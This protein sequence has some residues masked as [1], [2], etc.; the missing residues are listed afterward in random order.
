[1]PGGWINPLLS[2]CDE[3]NQIV[4]TVRARRQCGVALLIAKSWNIPIQVSTQLLD[5]NHRLFCGMDDATRGLYLW[6]FAWSSV[7]LGRRNFPPFSLKE[8]PS[9]T[10]YIL[11]FGFMIGL[12]LTVFGFFCWRVAIEEV[13]FVPVCTSFF[14]LEEL[15]A[16]FPRFVSCLTFLVLLSNQRLNPPESGELGFL[17]CHIRLV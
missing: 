15:F 5:V 9:S 16:E 6:S 13:C 10:V 1:M 2:D 17:S 14:H 11:S 8:A 3:R 4:G 7:L 12:A